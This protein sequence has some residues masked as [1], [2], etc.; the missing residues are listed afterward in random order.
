MT[1]MYWLSGGLTIALLAYLVY[2]LFK[3]EDLA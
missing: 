3:P 2:A 1:A